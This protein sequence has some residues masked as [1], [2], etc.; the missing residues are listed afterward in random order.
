METRNSYNQILLSFILREQVI[1]IASFGGNV[2][3]I[4]A[5]SQDSI[6]ETALAY[7]R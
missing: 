5:V 4:S 2:K 7:I 6:G 1:S 3:H